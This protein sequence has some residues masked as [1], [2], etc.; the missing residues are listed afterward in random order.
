[1]ETGKILKGK[2][3]NGKRV[4]FVSLLVFLSSEKEKRLNKLRFLKT[5]Q[6]DMLSV[7]KYV[8]DSCEV[9]GTSQSV[10][11]VPAM[12]VRSSELKLQGITSVFVCIRLLSNSSENEKLL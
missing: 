9:K 5:S 4:L 6:E 3:K 10:H 11:H 12:L 8:K 2:R 7:F 1:M